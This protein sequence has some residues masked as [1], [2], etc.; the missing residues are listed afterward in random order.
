MSAWFVPLPVFLEL[1]LKAEA[2]ADLLIVGNLD[3]LN[4]PVD[5]SGSQLRL[6]PNVTQ[7]IGKAFLPFLLK[8]HRLTAFLQ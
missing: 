3:A 7:I 4:Q 1:A 5:Q 6:F 8:L 2:D